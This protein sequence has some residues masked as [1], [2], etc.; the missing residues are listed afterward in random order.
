MKQLYVLSGTKTT[1]SD[2]NLARMANFLGGNARAFELGTASDLISNLSDDPLSPGITFAL[3]ADT[4]LDLYRQNN[5]REYLRNTLVCSTSEIF[6]YGCSPKSHDECIE[7]L[8]WGI[9]KEIKAVNDEGPR[10]LPL[11][12]KRFTHQ[13]AGSQYSGKRVSTS[14]AVFDGLAREPFALPLITIEGKPS[15]LCVQRQDC[16]L[17]FTTVSDLPN[18]QQRVF[19]EADL[20]GFY[21]ALL[22]VLVFLRAVFRE[23]CWQGGDKAARLIIDD[24]ALRRKYGNLD[25]RSLFSSLRKNRYSASVAYIPWNHFRTSKGLAPFFRSE[26]DRFS[27]CVHGCDHT[28]NEYGTL[29]GNLLLHKSQLAIQRMRRHEERTGI[30]FEPV[31]VFPQGRFSEPSLRALQCNGFLAAINSTRFTLEDESAAVQLGDLLLPAFS[32]LHGFPVFLRHYPT[33]IFPFLLDLFLGRPAFIVEHHEF[34]KDGLPKLE[35]LVRI[36]NSREPQ[37]SWGDLSET[38]KRVC[39]RRAISANSWEIMFFTDE[40][41]LTNDFEDSVLYRLVKHE[42]EP[43]MISSVSIDMLPAS[44]T[45][46]DEGIRLELSLKPGQTARI[47][48]QR[49]IAQ[50]PARIRVGSLYGSKVLLRRLLSE[51]R[52]EFLIQHPLLLSPAKHILRI[53][54]ASSDS[55]P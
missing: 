26:E 9:L 1:K 46:C 19:E 20:E 42:P 29:D 48:L 16:N 36:L 54:K 43:E 25:F 7:W 44:M 38:L 22:P 6:I 31:M 3:H 8:S 5:S 17:F 45:R 49:V 13:L 39:W 47:Q 52:D 34:F 14:S 12:G 18:P 27:I 55:P 15:F 41:I 28:N 24:P 33:D 37:L 10:D 21:D 4:L 30:G 51:V 23:F 2:E 50:S 53:L 11:T 35:S 40:F 32:R